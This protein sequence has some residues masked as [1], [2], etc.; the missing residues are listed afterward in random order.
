MQ[1][2]FV[3][4]LI[5]TVLI[6]LLSC[7]ISYEGVNFSGDEEANKISTLQAQATEVADSQSYS[8]PPPVTE[9][10]P[11]P[12]PTTQLAAPN[13]SEPE[14]STDNPTEYSVTSQNFDCICQETGTVTQEFKI[15]GDKLVLGD[16]TFDKIGDNT[17]RRSWMGYY[18][19]VSGEGDNKTETQVEE[20]RSSVVILTQDGYI[21]ENYQGDSG[22]P[23]CI[24]T[25]TK[26]E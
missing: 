14:T 9:P 16:Q 26:N 8:A 10:T 2:K 18:I 13:A 19:L 6:V 21:M 3:L 7:S 20:A 23:C 24:N 12:Q 11:E 17:F 1:K 25:F 22:S 5:L 4:P 15:E